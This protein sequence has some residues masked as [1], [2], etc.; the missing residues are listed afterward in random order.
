MARTYAA[1]EQWPN[2]E[3]LTGRVVRL[4][5]AG[6][7]EWQIACS[8]SV[9]QWMVTRLLRENGFHISV[10]GA[11]PYFLPAWSAARLGFGSRKRRSRA[12]IPLMARSLAGGRGT[13][14]RGFGYDLLV[15]E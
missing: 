9:S 1:E 8:T 12:R 14:R 3:M 11:M 7:S 13:A 6:V 10:P 5:M 2:R 15:G 4:R